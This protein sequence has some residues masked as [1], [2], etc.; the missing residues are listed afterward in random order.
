MLEARDRAWDALRKPIEQERKAA[1]SMMESIDKTHLAARTLAEMEAPLRR[2]IMA[3][4]TEVLLSAGNEPPERTAPLRRWKQDQEEINRRRYSS[5]L[6]SESAASALK[7]P[8]VS[9]RY[10]DNPTILRGFEILGANLD[11]AFQRLR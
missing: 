3:A 4:V 11:A 2:D 10:P 1:L 9:A 7:V 6:Y 5:H 8:V